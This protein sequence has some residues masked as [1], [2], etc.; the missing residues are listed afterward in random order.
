MNRTEEYY[1]LIAEYQNKYDMFARSIPK[2]LTLIAL[3]TN[4]YPNLSREEKNVIYE[5]L[6][7][8][9]AKYMSSDNIDKLILKNKF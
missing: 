2:N 7:H 6:R 3:L 8:V 5:A 1:K 4:K 9:E